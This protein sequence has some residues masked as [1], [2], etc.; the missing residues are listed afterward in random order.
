MKEQS[1]FY[2]QWSH[3]IFTFYCVIPCFTD[4][5]ISKIFPSWVFLQ[6]HIVTTKNSV[7]FSSKL[8]SMKTI[9]MNLVTHLKKVAF[10]LLSK[11]WKKNKTDE[12]DTV[13]IIFFFILC[14]IKM[15]WNYLFEVAACDFHG[16]LG[17]WNV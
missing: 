1:F 11:E 12:S 8:N 14:D 9:Y 2:R 16:N 10:F 13:C 4:L 7:L 3:F 5:L 17:P 15:S 6:Y